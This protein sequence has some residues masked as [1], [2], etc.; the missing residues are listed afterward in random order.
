MIRT[1]FRFV[2]LMRDSVLKALIHCWSQMTRLQLYPRLSFLYTRTWML[3]RIYGVVLTQSVACVQRIHPEKI[4]AIT[5]GKIPSTPAVE[6]L[7]GLSGI[8]FAIHYGN[9]C[10]DAYDNMIVVPPQVRADLQ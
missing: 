4:S 10:S 1:T 9:R 3:V 2:A 6:R 7:G 8:A 5:R